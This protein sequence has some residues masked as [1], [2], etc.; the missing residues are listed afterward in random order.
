[1]CIRD[2]VHGDLILGIEHV[3]VVLARD[4]LVVQAIPHVGVDEVGA[5]DAV[6]Y[7]QDVYKRQPQA[8]CPRRARETHAGGRRIY[9]GA[10]TPGTS[11][12]SS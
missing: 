2:S 6:S 8:P 11:G 12:Y 5:L 4:L 7:T 9:A 1:M 10:K 3:H